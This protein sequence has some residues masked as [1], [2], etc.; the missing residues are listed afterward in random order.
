M[1][2]GERETK[3]ESK[4]KKD[5]K[6]LTKEGG[7][8]MIVFLLNDKSY[9]PFYLKVWKAHS[10]NSHR[11]KCNRRNSDREKEIFRAREI[12]NGE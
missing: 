5:K 11:E 12:E 6:E 9:I 1:R 3:R 2:E 10:T 7:L 8:N 4:Q